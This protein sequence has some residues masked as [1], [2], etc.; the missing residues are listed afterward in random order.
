MCN[1]LHMSRTYLIV[2]TDRFILGLM[3]FQTLFLFFML[4]FYGYYEDTATLSTSSVVCDPKMNVVKSLPI[5]VDVVMTF[6]VQYPPES[7]LRFGASLREFCSYRDCLII[8]FVGANDLK[9]DDIRLIAHTYHM[10]LL[11]MHYGEFAPSIWESVFSFSKRFHRPVTSSLDFFTQTNTAGYRFGYQLAWMI[12]YSQQNG[13][14]PLRYMLVTDF[15]DAFFQGNLFDRIPSVFEDWTTQ[16]KKDTTEIRML[17]LPHARWETK[18]DMHRLDQTALSVIKYDGAPHRQRPWV[19]GFPEGRRTSIG[20]CTYNRAWLAEVYGDG[21]AE[22]LKDGFVIC[23]GTTLGNAAGVLFWLRRLVYEIDLHA[24]KKHYN[25][26]DQGIHNYL[27]HKD[28]LSGGVDVFLANNEY[29]SLVVTTGQMTSVRQ[30]VLGFVETQDGP[31]LFPAM[32][33]QFDRIV[34]VKEGL[35]R[36]YSLLKKTQLHS[37]YPHS[38]AQVREKRKSHVG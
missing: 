14:V 8:V 13:S 10:T 20:K 5:Y 25:S 16:R 31:G 7:F 6:A 9:N 28:Q 12:H 30:N 17:H 34:A 35:E 26:N 4:H 15:R 36:K 2:T 29:N 22:E 23:A 11:L 37:Y 27:L 24:Q 33:H 19:M 38:N 1:R 3:L 21:I 18:Q 32:I